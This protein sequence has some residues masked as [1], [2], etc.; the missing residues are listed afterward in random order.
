MN[1]SPFGRF[2][3]ADGEILLLD[4]CARYLEMAAPKGIQSKDLLEADLKTDDLTTLEGIP[5]HAERLRHIRTVYEKA[6]QKRG[7]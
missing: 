7:V 1:S 4:A 5:V 6:W 3:S 2:V